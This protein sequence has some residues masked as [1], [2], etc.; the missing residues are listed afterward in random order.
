[1]FLLANKE[2]LKS[3]TERLEARKKCADCRPPH[4]QI[5]LDA[6][7]KYNRKRFAITL[8]LF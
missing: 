3:V 4:F 5:N 7:K 2:Y 8:L 1:M 6:N